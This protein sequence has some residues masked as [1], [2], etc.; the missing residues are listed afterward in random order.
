MKNE[1]ISNKQLVEELNKPI[2][3]KFN[4]RK[5][6]S[7]FIDNIWRADLIDVQL[8]SKLYKGFSFLLC[9]INIYRKYAWFI[10]LKNKKRIIITNFKTFQINQITNQIKYGQIKEANFIID[11]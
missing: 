10:H 5:V 8:I 6:H 7:P 11:Q 2:I 1:N 4:K 9:V 3:R